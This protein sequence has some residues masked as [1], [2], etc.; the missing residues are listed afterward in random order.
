V[1][2]LPVAAVLSRA[3]NERHLRSALPD[4]PVVPDT[5]GLVAPVVVRVRRATARAL[6]GAARVVDPVP[7][8]PRRCVPTSRCC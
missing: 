1:D 2:N 4:A 5:A 7:A 8:S 6:E 3:F